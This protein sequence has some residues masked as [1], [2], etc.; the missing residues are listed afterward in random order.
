MY[1]T[2]VKIP[3]ER[4]AVLIGIKGE[5]KRAI[6]QTTQCKLDIDSTE[7]DVFISGED[8]VGMMVA[9]DIIKAIGRGFNPEVA[10][11]LTKQDY[12]LELI[13]ISDYAKNQNDLVRVRGRII[14]KEGK[15]RRKFETLTQ[16]SISVFGKTVAI[17][18]EI[19]K[20]SKAKQS[21]ENLLKGSPH[22]KVYGRILKK[23]KD[24]FRRNILEVDRIDE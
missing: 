13:D 18:G 9:K 5:Q 17:I 23:N 11:R 2:D 15:A 6:E 24:H 14:G 19:E 20:V 3:K 8:S 21:I 12:C 4:I 10:L 7:G 1:Q 16:T 22:N